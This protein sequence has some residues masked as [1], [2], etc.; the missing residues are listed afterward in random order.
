MKTKEFIQRYKIV[1]LLSFLV[2]VL[3]I[4]KIKYGDLNKDDQKLIPTP[5]VIPTLT[6]ELTSF[7]EE[8]IDEV[9]KE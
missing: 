8:Y 3:I 2:V 6:I 4:L 7:P 1:L 5:T 9:N